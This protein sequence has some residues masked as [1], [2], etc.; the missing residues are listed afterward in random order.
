[1]AGCRTRIFFFFCE[2]GAW[3]QGFT[4][5][6]QVLYR[7][8]HTSSPFCSCYFR[9]GVSWTICLGWPGTVILHILAS[10]VDRIAG[11]SHWHLTRT[12]NLNKGPDDGP[13]VHGLAICNY[14][15]IWK[16]VSEMKS[17]IFPFFFF[18]RYWGLNSGPL[19]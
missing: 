14:S 1:L 13:L 8:S 9:D 17:S 15:C 18:L 12:G 19:P 7:L 16:E 4:L 6:K 10:Q 11:V 3:T 5:A 2:T